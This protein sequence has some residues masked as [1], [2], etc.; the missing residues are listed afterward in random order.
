[1]FQD[2][3]LDEKPQQA[4]AACKSEDKDVNT[5]CVKGAQRGETGPQTIEGF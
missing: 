3:V 4:A 2:S 5:E 1:M